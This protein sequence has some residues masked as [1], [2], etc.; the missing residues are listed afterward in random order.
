ME[1][2]AG[3][4]AHRWEIAHGLQRPLGVWKDWTQSGVK[5]GEWEG[6]TVDERRL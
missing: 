2:T 5:G 6:G 1:A 4:K 3:R